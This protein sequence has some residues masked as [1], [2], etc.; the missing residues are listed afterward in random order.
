MVIN[1]ILEFFRLLVLGSGETKDYVLG[2]L[3]NFFKNLFMIRDL[4]IVNVLIVLIN[5]FSKKE[6]KENIFNV[7]LFFENIN[8]Y[9]KKR[10]KIYF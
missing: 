4:L 7:F 10:G 6:I 1:Y 5:I 9:F 3:V 2:M 8:R